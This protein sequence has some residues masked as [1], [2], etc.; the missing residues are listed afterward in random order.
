MKL[1][2]NT[3]V[4]ILFDEREFQFYLS[5]LNSYVELKMNF[6]RKDTILPVYFIITPRPEHPNNSRKKIH[7]LERETLVK[8]GH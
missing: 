1:Y 4:K 5:W 7:E 3:R 8:E 6:N 2:P